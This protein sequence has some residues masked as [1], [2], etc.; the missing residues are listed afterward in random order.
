MITGIAISTIS[1]SGFSPSLVEPVAEGLDVERRRSSYRIA[2]C[3]ETE[4]DTT[5]SFSTGSIK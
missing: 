4:D 5:A 1:L 2:V 3:M